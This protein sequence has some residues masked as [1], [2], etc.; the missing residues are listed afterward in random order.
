[1]SAAL[2]VVPGPLEWTSGEWVNVPLAVPLA[3]LAFG[4]AA[5]LLSLPSRELRQRLQLVD[6][7]NASVDPR[8]GLLHHVDVLLG[9][10]ATRFGAD[11]AVLSLQGPQPRI[12]RRSR[13][14]GTCLLDDAQ[15][16]CWHARRAALRDTAGCLCSSSGRARAVGVSMEG[17]GEKTFDI[18]G[19]AREVLL[20]MAPESAALLLMSYGKPLGHLCLERQATP[21]TVA[22]LRWLRDA[23][24]EL[25][26][27][28][29]RCDLLEQLQRE[30]AAAERE[31]IGRDLHDSAVQPYL[32][33]KYGLEALARRATRDNPLAPALD[34]LVQLT[35]D[36]LQRLRDVVTGLRKGD[37]P[38]AT[39]V[40]MEALQRQ[41]ARFEA[42][43]GLK[44][45]ID[46]SQAVGLRGSV[47]SAVLHMF[48][49]ALTNVRRHTAAT[50]VTVSLDMLDDGLA[51]TVR[52]DHGG[53]RPP[54]SSFVPRSLTERAIEVGGGVTVD[55][56]E[57]STAVSIRL[58][59]F[60]SFG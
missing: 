38:A 31:R 40:F 52:N 14:G 57:D 36:E 59:L 13:G 12:F 44:V 8:Q 23:M 33:L 51:M 9:L 28:L 4:P 45:N 6:A 3:V 55:V 34:Q 11:A 15:A 46:A 37:D 48:N 53:A 49:E 7:F 56:R 50:T 20:A 39:T 26:P 60:R 18:E 47:A 58:P 27:L 25:V 43:Y 5:A 29:E 1:V 17:S 10:L 30:T 41:A 42:L 16:A 22:D 19:E 2:M 32:G 21:F 35:N 54:A 24:R